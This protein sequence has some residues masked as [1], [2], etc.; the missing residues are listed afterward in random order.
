MAIEAKEIPKIL[1]YIFL[2]GLSSYAAVWVAG[3]LREEVVAVARS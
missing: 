3:K 2:I 1:F